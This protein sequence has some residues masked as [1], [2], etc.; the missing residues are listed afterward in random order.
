MHTKK[1]D[2]MV[3]NKPVE[4]GLFP[5]AIAM[6]AIFVFLQ[7]ILFNGYDPQTDVYVSLI[8]SYSFVALIIGFFYYVYR[9]NK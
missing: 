4:I 9:N 2:I 3:K 7:Y 8:I 6:I 5:I 1:G